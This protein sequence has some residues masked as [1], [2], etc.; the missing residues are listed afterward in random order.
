MANLVG[1]GLPLLRA[2]ELSRDATQNRS[3]ASH[4]DQVIEQVGDG[5]SFSKALI[6]T[7]VVSRRC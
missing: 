7:E 4:L 3:C 2:L 5:R 6:R 1:N